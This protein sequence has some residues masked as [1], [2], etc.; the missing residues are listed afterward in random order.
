MQGIRRTGFTGRQ[1]SKR[2]A[3]S[4]SSQ[5]KG[6]D[7]S[8][9]PSVHPRQLCRIEQKEQ[10]TALA[11]FQASRNAAFATSKR[12]QGQARTSRLLILS[13]QHPTLPSTRYQVMDTLHRESLPELGGAKG[14]VT[15]SPYVRNASKKLPRPARRCDWLTVLSF[16]FARTV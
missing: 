7:P 11:R 10:N 14:L 12:G 6:P 9:H 16:S 1:P 4:R 5:Q 13:Y 2:N 15:E 3:S 8:T